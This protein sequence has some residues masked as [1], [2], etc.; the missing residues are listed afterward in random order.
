MVKTRRRRPK[1][2]KPPV[3]PIPEHIEKGDCVVYMLQRID[4]HHAVLVDHVVTSH[5]T[6]KRFEHHLLNYFKSE[7]VRMEPRLSPPGL[8]SRAQIKFG[9]TKNLTKRLEDINDDIFDSGV[10]EWRALSWP[11]LVIAHRKF[12]WMRNK[13]RVYGFIF[14]LLVV[15]AGIIYLG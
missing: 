7:S 8:F 11:A 9:V 4:F 5:N 3:Q 2:G 13:G 14:L 1:K 6:M 15:L 12:W 10:T